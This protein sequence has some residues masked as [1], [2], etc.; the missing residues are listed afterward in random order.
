[1]CADKGFAGV[2][3]G[4][5]H[6]RGILCGQLLLMLASSMQRGPLIQ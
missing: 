6:A 5:E 1:M 4:G 3:P 2:E